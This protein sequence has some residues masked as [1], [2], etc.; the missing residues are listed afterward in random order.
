MSKTP[1]KNII[2]AGRKFYK[3]NVMSFDSAHTSYYRCQ[4]QEK[5]FTKIKSQ[6]WASETW[7]Q[8]FTISL[9]S[10]VATRHQIP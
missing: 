5:S 8:T 3:M 7:K 9:E 6:C 4:V 2:E 1:S 10:F